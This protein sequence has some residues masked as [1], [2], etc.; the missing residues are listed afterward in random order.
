MRHSVVGAPALAQAQAT[1]SRCAA[2]RSGHYTLH[3]HASAQRSDC[4]CCSGG[5]GGGDGCC[6][7]W[8]PDTI[9]PPPAPQPRFNRHIMLH[10]IS[11]AAC[12]PRHRQRVGAQRA[13]LGPPAKRVSFNLI[14][15]MRIIVMRS[16]SGGQCRQVR[17]RSRTRA[18][19]NRPVQ[20][21]EDGDNGDGDNCD[22]TRNKIT[23][24]QC[25]MDSY[26][27]VYSISYIAALQQC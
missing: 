10:F 1:V 5:D 12:R 14:K 15:H 11:S 6:C 16:R 8:A 21:G 18:R 20:S 4:F 2:P 9:S 25:E 13:Q 26:Q 7:C 27:G 19:G 23:A 3:T 17:R 22:S 24:R